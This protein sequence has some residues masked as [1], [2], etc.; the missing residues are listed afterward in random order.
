MQCQDNCVPG[1]FV[2]N[3]IWKAVSVSQ[4]ILKLTQPS[5]AVLRTSVPIIPKK[6]M[7]GVTDFPEDLHF[8]KS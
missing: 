3:I 1:C 6:K 7:S 5:C 4:S 2:I 8:A